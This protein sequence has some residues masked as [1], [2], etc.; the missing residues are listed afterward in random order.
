MKRIFLF[1]LSLV[2]C[3]T[4]FAFT[5][6]AAEFKF[7]DVPESAWYYADVKSAV[8]M[9]LINGKSTTEY[10]PDDN[11]TYA[12]AIKLAACMH[13]LYMDGMITL[14]NGDPWYQTYVD[15]C[16]DKN[17]IN[18]EY[19][20]NAKATRSGY[21]VIF[22]H[23]LP[24]EALKKTNSVPDDSIPDVPSTRAYAP[25]VYKLYR[26]GILQG[27]DAAHSCKPFDNIKRSEVAAILSRMMDES[28][29]VKFSIG[30]EELEEPE[31]KEEE[32]EE[33]EPLV[34]KTQPKDVTV[35]MSG[36]KATFT[37]EVEGGVGPYNYQWYV[38]DGGTLYEIRD[39]GEWI[40]GA[41]TNEFTFIP[42]EA[43]N[44]SII[45]IISDAEANIIETNVVALICKDEAKEE[46]TEGETTEGETA[47]SDALAIKLQPMS[48]S[49]KA[50]EATFFGVEAKGGKTPYTYQWQML[51]G[52]EW[53]NITTSAFYQGVT[54]NQL[55]AIYSRD[56][57]ET[58]RCVVTDA[59]GD[60]VTTNEAKFIVTMEAPAL[61][62]RMQPEDASVNVGKSVKLTVAAMGGA[63]DY[64]Y[65]WQYSNGATW[66][67]F[68]EGLY[69]A[70]GITAQTL[71]LTP[72]EAGTIT[73]RC[74][75]AD[76]DGT[77]V[78]TDSATVTVAEVL[79]NEDFAFTIDGVY[80]VASRS[81][82]L[83]GSVTAGKVNVG[84]TVYLNDASGKYVATTTVKAMEIS[85]NLVDESKKGDKP[86]INVD[87]DVDTYKSYDFDGCVLSATKGSSSL[88]TRPSTSRPTGT[89]TSAALAVKSASDDQKGSIG[90]FRLAVE[91]V[92]GKA[93][94]TYQ[95]QRLVTITIGAKQS[96][97]YVNLVDTDGKIQGA[98]TANLT[99]SL[100][101][102]DTYKYKCVITDADGNS[103]IT[104]AI[105]IT[106]NSESTG[107]RVSIPSTGK[108]S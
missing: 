27:S 69:G 85:K 86:G 88:G 101:E 16:F 17:I 36:T 73:V 56:C 102:L 95:W 7:T 46:A 2:M 94:Y 38:V 47:E 80:N 4:A 15:Y 41:S 60:T 29:R 61:A 19:D 83:T 28:K 105:T 82:V 84:D 107:G 3:T 76:K 68:N 78:I 10:K 96:Q 100:T 89:T 54:T 77:P 91:A 23:A 63:G 37:V 44:E 70:T 52:E 81:I 24:D 108:N 21:M 34:I 25:E 43:C 98:K 58:I 71:T 59:N 18:T 45:C 79:K 12:E 50:K 11:L 1:V 57:E 6:N 13:Q 39:E 65:Q 67:T 33:V 51:D 42:D 87:L 20:Y 92:G 5:A 53:K 74:I 75:I 49:V 93:P 62:V 90:L 14:K 9:G 22:A 26:A 99:L 48:Q 8:E 72:T 64:R 106:V 66:S 32:K 103:V 35:E 104:D 40:K 55:K 31:V 97:R 30:E